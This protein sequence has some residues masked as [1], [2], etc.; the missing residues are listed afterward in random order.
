MKHALTYP[1]IVWML[2]LTTGLRVQVHFMGDKLYDASLF[3]EPE[4][5]CNIQCGCCEET[6]YAFKL[7]TDFLTSSPQVVPAVKAGVMPVA[8]PMPV[9]TWL[10]KCR[11][12]TTC[13]S[14]SKNL[15]RPPLLQVFLL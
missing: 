13:P 12:Y 6:T 2:L 15:P 8:T 7:D 5:C 1:L 11:V 14:F 9:F 4:S 10:Q 3:G